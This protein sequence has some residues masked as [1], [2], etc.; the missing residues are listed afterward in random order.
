[1]AAYNPPLHPECVLF[2][3]D[4]FVSVVQQ[5]SSTPQTLSTAPAVQTVSQHT[6]SFGRLK[7][8]EPTT[9][10]ASKLIYTEDLINFD[11]K[12][13][14]STGTGT[15]VYYNNEAKVRLTT[16]G[17]SSVTRQTFQYFNYNPGVSQLVVI[18]GIFNEG[19]NTTTTKEWGFGDAQNGLFFKLINGTL[20]TCIRSF[21]TGV[22]VDLN[23]AQSSFNVNKLLSGDVILDTKKNNIY[24]IEFGWLGIA[25]VN[26]G[27]LMNGQQIVMDSRRNENSNT[28][29]Y[30]S[31]PNL[32]IR[33]KIT[34]TGNETSYMD[35]VCCAVI[36]QGPTV[37]FGT[38]HS[39]S[40]FPSSVTGFTVANAQ[41]NSYFPILAIK[42]TKAGTQIIITTIT[43]VNS[44]ST[45]PF[46]WIICLNP[47]LSGA[48]PVA[49]TTANSNI[50]YGVH[51][52]A[53]A[54]T[55][56]SISVLKTVLQGGIGTNNAIVGD[57]TIS[58][59]LR[60]G[61]SIDGVFD[62]LYLAVR[63]TGGSNLFFANLE[64]NEF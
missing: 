18:T 25:T 50:N 49:L 21:A 33:F 36:S 6:D 28:V 12:I 47:T 7:V 23:V 40:S 51:P 20:Y 1:M 4:N 34:N 53:A 19:S 27:I 41:A 48:F 32:P 64:Y 42:P 15:S 55:S 45:N 24:F 17:T 16:T 11:T 9:V 10:F 29:V 43:I 44:G 58:S 57:H 8:A 14:N 46:E 26:F 13:V 61:L 5:K 2:N 56:P 37:T 63:T 39:I 59:N 35:C 3:L 22:A 30:M 60:M 62:T 31:T 54:T 52:T 38:F